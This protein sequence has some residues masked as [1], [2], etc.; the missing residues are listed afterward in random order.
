ML[1]I[2]YKQSHRIYGMLFSASLAT[3]LSPACFRVFEMNIS[4][5]Y[6]PTVSDR[7]LDARP[8]RWTEYG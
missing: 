8:S 4:C 7:K 3:G 6:T 2:I 1:G 5:V